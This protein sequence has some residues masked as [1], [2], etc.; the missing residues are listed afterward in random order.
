MID[1]D[2][3][4]VEGPSD[5]LYLQA[6]SR[7][8]ESLGRVHL[9]P[10]WAMCPSGGVDKVLPFVRLFYGND[11]NTVVLTDFDRGQTGDLDELYKSGLLERERIILTSEIAGQ[12]EADIE[13][14]FTRELFVELINRTFQLESDDRLTVSRLMTADEN[15]ERAV[16]KAEAYF[17]SLPGRISMFSRYSPALYLLR[18]PELL[19]GNEPAVEQTLD[20]F[21]DAFRRIEKYARRWYSPDSWGR[22]T[23]AVMPPA[24]EV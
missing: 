1:P 17:R 7:K 11:L 24:G 16:K 8:L 15:T 19:E 21:E 10:K 2:T 6:L 20:T 14:F 13:D 18:N 3:L 9:D 22:R 4:L 23:G 12:T 5:I